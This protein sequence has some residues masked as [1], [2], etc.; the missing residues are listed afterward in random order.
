MTHGKTR[1]AAQLELPPEERPRRAH[2]DDVV[3]W[4]APP[5]DPA[6]ADRLPSSVTP[7]EAASAAL[8]DVFLAED[9][10]LRHYEA[11]RI[12]QCLLQEDEAR[13]RADGEKITTRE[14][15]LR[16]HV[17]KLMYVE[18]SRLLVLRLRA[19]EKLEGARAELAWRSR[20]G[21]KP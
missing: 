9:D 18:G 3:Q 14:E 21:N 15:E 5:A 10:L 4:P 2:I 8:Q 7:F 6:P 12:L 19:Q 20:Q 1:A 16:G 13:R 11:A 17:L